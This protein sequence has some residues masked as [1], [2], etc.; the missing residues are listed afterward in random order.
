MGFSHDNAHE[1]IENRTK[2]SDNNIP[3]NAA[4]AFENK[5]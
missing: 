4:K 3:L 2:I 5:L 1:K